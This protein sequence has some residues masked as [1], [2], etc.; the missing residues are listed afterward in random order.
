[1]LMYV[2]E[3]VALLAA[4]AMIPGV[5]GAV[6]MAAATETPSPAPIETNPNTAAA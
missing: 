4:G 5:K 6:T 2:S 3:A 1:M